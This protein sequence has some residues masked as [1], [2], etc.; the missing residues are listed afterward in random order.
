M[1]S[2]QLEALDRSGHRKYRKTGSPIL[3]Q[4]LYTTALPP[5]HTSSRKGLEERAEYR[6]L[7]YFISFIL[8]VCF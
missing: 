6:F 1:L 8:F 3:K 7:F 4:V 2:Q 5:T